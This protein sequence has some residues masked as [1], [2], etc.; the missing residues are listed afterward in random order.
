ML[1]SNK[2]DEKVPLFT[3]NLFIEDLDDFES[4]HPFVCVNISQSGPKTFYLSSVA[5]YHISMNQV[6]KS[7]TDAGP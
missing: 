7:Q 4:I 3:T 1:A 5:S 2:T 6:Y